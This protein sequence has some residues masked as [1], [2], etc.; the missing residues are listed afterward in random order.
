MTNVLA[1][2]ARSTP[3][4]LTTRSC[5]SSCSLRVPQTFQGRNQLQPYALRF[6]STNAAASGAKSAQITAIRPNQLH[7]KIGQIVRCEKHP[8]A[9]KLYVSQVAVTPTAAAAAAAANDPNTTS[10][11]GLITVCSG[12]RDF[13]PLSELQGR[14][15]VLINNLKASKMRG[16]KSEA[17]LLAA[18]K[19][20]FKNTSITEENKDAEPEPEAIVKV[21]LVNPPLGSAVGA[22]LVFKALSDLTENI[23]VEETGTENAGAN[24][25]ANA[26][27]ATPTFKKVKDLKKLAAILDGLRTNDAKFVSFIDNDDT[28]LQAQA[29]KNKDEYFLVDPVVEAR[30]QAE[31][32]G[33]AEEDKK[34]QYVAFADMLSGAVVR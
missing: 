23:K 18:E 32:A 27:P 28:A 29:Q 13:I 34:K 4:K 21:E 33:G 20:T 3:A 22:N 26:N 30:V 10:T 6:S 1:L 15:V 14:K 24:A 7:Y 17:M 2:S 19:K 12:L 11:E 31:D 25:N 5:L 16:V 9:D 8:L